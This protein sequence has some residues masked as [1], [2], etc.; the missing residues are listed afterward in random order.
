MFF[1]LALGA[2]MAAVVYNP[3]AG[4]YAFIFVLLSLCIW[5]RRWHRKS[6]ANPWRPFS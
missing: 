5:Q 6:V 4:F 2:A 3:V 1:P